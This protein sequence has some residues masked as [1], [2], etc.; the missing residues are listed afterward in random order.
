MALSG[1]KCQKWSRHYR[2]LIT[3]GQAQYLARTRRGTIWQPWHGFCQG[4]YEVTASNGSIPGQRK[5]GSYEQAILE[6]AW[7]AGKHQVRRIS[8][9]W[10][11]LG[12][13]GHCSGPAR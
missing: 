10:D 5:G 1:Y 9:D 7:L 6:Q 12:P 13:P 2:D 11:S 8:R 4:P 3:G